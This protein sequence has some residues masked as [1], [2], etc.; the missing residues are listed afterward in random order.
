M[1]YT[2][3]G[4]ADVSLSESRIRTELTAALEKLGPRRRVVAVP[5]DMS[6]VHSGA[7]RLTEMTWEHYGDALETVLPATGTHF[8]MSEAELEEM[9]GRIPHTLFRVHDWQ[10]DLVTLGTVPAEFVSEVAEGRFEEPWPAQ[11]NA[12]LVHGGYDLILSIGQVVPHEV[13]G[14]ANYNKNIFIGTGGR[15]SIH[16]SH[17][18]GAVYG[19][20]RMM[21]KVD[22]PVRRVLNYASERFAGDLPVVYVLTVIGRDEA[23][24]LVM[25]GLF[26]GDDEDC[27]RRAAA[28]SREVNVTELPERVDTVV[29]YLDPK[30]YKSTW[31]GNK[32][33]YRSR[34]AIADGGRLIVLAPGVHTF[35]ENAEI[36]E[37]IRAYGYIG[38]D[39]V[40]ERVEA[41][42]AGL[43][44]NLAAAAHLIHGSA[45]GRFSITYCPGGVSQEEVESVNYRYA[46]LEEMTARYLPDDGR[47]G[48]HETAD[49][50]PYYFISNP[51]LGLWTAEA[52]GE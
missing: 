52:P 35:G 32:A 8:P 13:V 46:E 38:T 47:I 31:I 45:E 17:Y 20:E 36:D 21:G 6:R 7:G 50:E 29:V 16:K 12:S 37:L 14:M 26:I 10:R 42:H 33:V 1:T 18:L 34:M 41:R 3:V 28:L 5:P 44:G 2:A 11:V 4:G 19:L 40:I 25:R 24:E 43:A 27:F 30:E 22:T 51:G 15:E 23:G 49:G 9:Y 39:E 48:M